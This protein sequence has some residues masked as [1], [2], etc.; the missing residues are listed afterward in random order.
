M[1]HGNVV[2]YASRR[3]K[4]HEKDYP[5]HDLEMAAVVFGLKLWR[6]YLYGELFEVYTITRV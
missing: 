3:L 6:H 1:Q 5:T 2:V 4:D